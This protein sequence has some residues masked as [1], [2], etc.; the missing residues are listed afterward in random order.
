MST[1]VQASTPISGDPGPTQAI[2]VG[3]TPKS[4]AELGVVLTKDGY[5][6]RSLYITVET[7]DIRF[8]LGGAAPDSSSSRGHVLASG[9]SKW[10]SNTT[11]VESFKV[12]NKTADSVAV[13]QVTPEF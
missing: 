2:T 4:L 8:A 10:I 5:P 12:C 3:N 1:Y 6:A 7:N 11:A 9:G 13:I